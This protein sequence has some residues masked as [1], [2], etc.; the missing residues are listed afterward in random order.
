[1][2]CIKYNVI[3]VYCCIPFIYFRFILRSLR[4]ELNIVLNAMLWIKL[5]AF[6]WTW[7]R[8]KI[9]IVLSLMVIICIASFKCRTHL[10]YILGCSM[11]CA[12]QKHSKSRS[13]PCVQPLWTWK[14]HPGLWCCINWH[15]GREHSCWLTSDKYIQYGIILSIYIWCGG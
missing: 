4:Y 13:I 11:P 2:Y 5:M 1:M 3:L 15:F 9:C 14:H 6:S 8:L 12:D 10:Y 7:S